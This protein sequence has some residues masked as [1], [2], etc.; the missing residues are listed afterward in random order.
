MGM[1][2]SILAPIFIL[3]VTGFGTATELPA[4]MNKA[5]TQQ[6]SGTAATKPSGNTTQVVTHK[7]P[8]TPAHKTRQS[9]SRL[10]KRKTKPKH[11]APHAHAEIK[12]ASAASLMRNRRESPMYHYFE[13][14]SAGANGIQAPASSQN[15]HWLTISP[16]DRT[17]AGRYC[18]SIG[19][20]AEY[21]PLAAEMVIAQAPVLARTEIANTRD[22]NDASELT[23]LK[24]MKAMQ[25]GLDEKSET[26]PADGLTFKILETAYTYL[27]V[28]YRYGGTTPE[29]FDCS[30]F[31][32]YV[33]NENGIQLGRSS[34]DQAQEGTRVPLTA[35][36]PG[37]LIFF[38]MGS[39]KHH[40]IDHVGLYIGDGQFIHAA[41]SRSRQIMISD[42]K[43]AHYQRRVVTARRVTS[44]IP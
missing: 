27:G 3:F 40:R 24:Q 12:K 37:D 35:L 44:S 26:E 30:G 2:I 31:V 1:R 38:N 20:E 10:A 39:R 33:F 13:F 21:P 29:G 11:V 4:S 32:R 34:R 16:P 18:L 25:A 17:G 15:G 19:T 43:S 14:M 41:S 42:L 7:K 28:R 23:D 22:D 9:K 5:Q 8:A 36:K 6:F